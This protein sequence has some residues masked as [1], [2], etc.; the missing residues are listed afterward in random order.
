MATG[1][2]EIYGAIGA[3]VGILN[4]AQ[5]GI[6]SLVDSY[7]EYKDVGQSISKV[8][9]DCKSLCF[10]ISQWSKYW[11]FHIKMDDEMYKALWSEEGWPLI[12]QQ[13]AAT[14]LE[15]AD[16]AT[17]VHRKI[18][19]TIP[20]EQIPEDFRKRAEALLKEKTLCAEDSNTPD[21]E[22]YENSKV[23]LG[24]I[25]QKSPKESRIKMLRIGHRYI[26]QSTPH[27]DKIK[28]VLR[29]SRKLERKLES[30]TQS[31]EKLKGLVDDAR[32]SE[33]SAA[34]PRGWTFR[35]IRVIAL[36]KIHRPILH[37]AKS[38]RLDMEILYECC[39]A[40]LQSP[41]VEL[42]IMKREGKIFGGK[43]FPILISQSEHGITAEI[44]G[45]SSPVPEPGMLGRNFD[46]ACKKAQKAGQSHLCASANDPDAGGNGRRTTWFKLCNACPPMQ[47]RGIPICS[48][49]AKLK[50]LTKAERLDLAYIVV[51][52]ALL[53]LGT[54]WLS[55]LS[56]TTLKR[57]EQRGEQQETIVKYFCDLKG[58]KDSFLHRLQCDTRNVHVYIFT[59]GA[60]LVE[61][62]L[63][64]IITEVVDSYH[65]LEMRMAKPSGP[66]SLR[67]VV[68]NVQASLGE[69][70][71]EAVNFCLQDPKSAPNRQWQGGVLYDPTCTEEEVSVE[72]L[73]LFYSEAFIR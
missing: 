36:T 29:H 19:A 11:C 32:L 41:K 67:K 52:S 2:F 57:L 48:L 33:E 51:E 65:G 58:L 17:M 68:H 71:S 22:S 38:N 5:L 43:S 26:G 55:T 15:F 66:Y 37:E 46:D 18:P 49:N 1:F 12:E 59:V 28:Y 16:F 69:E 4:L 62:A 30:L 50:T 61:I 60:I 7:K 72:L 14:E 6:R 35:E 20:Y 42:N 21:F 56:S 70:Y 64:M 13:L 10:R 24:E 44:L 34:Y 25:L 73:D 23:D 31:F 45:D 8:Q 47:L 39:S 63:G 40:S 27:A 9:L 53:L 54:S 3:T